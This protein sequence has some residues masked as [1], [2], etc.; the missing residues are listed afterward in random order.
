MPTIP[1]VQIIDVDPAT[2]ESWLAKNPNNR[3]LR[4]PVVQS[5]A[6]DMVSGNWMLNGETIKFDQ[7]GKLID[8]QHRLSAVVT[9]DV[10]VPWSSCEAWMLTSW[11]RST[12][13]RNAATRTH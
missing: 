9:A 1:T 3:N 11:T 5:Y 10:T 6:R 8:G 12:S 7:S 2:A 4:V 13:A